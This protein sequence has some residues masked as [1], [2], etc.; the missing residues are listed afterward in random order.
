MSESESVSVGVSPS[1]FIDED[2]GDA[3]AS[4]GMPS[5]GDTGGRSRSSIFE[6]LQ[7][8][9]PSE[10]PEMQDGTL[11]TNAKWYQHAELAV[12]KMTGSTGT[13][14]WVN[15]CM[16]TLMLVAD[17]AG[18]APDSSDEQGG[19]A[20]QGAGGGPGGQSFEGDSEISI[21]GPDRG[22]GA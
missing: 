1:E 15:G 16:A 13:P 2:A 11:S 3:D 8:T 19:R 4:E 12:K 21:V 20:D 9:E 6:M 5:M 17:A 7:S 18:V 10:S 22:Q 14:A